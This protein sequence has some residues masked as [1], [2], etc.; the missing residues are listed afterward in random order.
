[1]GWVLGILTISGIVIGFAK[2]IWSVFDS[3]YRKSQQRKNV[4]SNLSRVSDKVQNSM[5]EGLDSFMPKVESELEMFKVALKKPVQYVIISFFLM[6][7]LLLFIS[8]VVLC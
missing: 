7:L 8:Y 3:D 2:A 4:D 5:R 6:F 1:M